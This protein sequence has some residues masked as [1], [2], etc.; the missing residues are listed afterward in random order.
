MAPPTHLSSKELEMKKALMVAL[1]AMSPTT[2]LMAEDIDLGIQRRILGAT[3]K[4]QMSNT[5]D[6]SRI[7]SGGSGT[8]I[9]NSRHIGEDGVLRRI[10]IATAEHVI[11]QSFL[12]EGGD[13]PGQEPVLTDISVHN[14]TAYIRD[15]TGQV[16]GEDKFTPY[17]SRLVSSYR[18]Y[19]YKSVDAAFIVMD[20][21]PGCLWMSGVE[22]VAM[23]GTPLA[24]SLQI[25]SELL[26]AGCPIMVDPILFRN[27]LVQRNM[28]KLGF[29]TRDFLGHLVSRVLTHGN[30]GGGIYTSDGKYIGIV[31]LRI[32]DDFGAFTGIE[33]IL[34]LSILDRDVMLLM[35]P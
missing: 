15:S 10:V 22:A 16:R 19:R 32:G 4:I 34:P 31:T 2:C 30:S 7:S 5:F 20:L 25:G 14:F 33:H 6:V 27:R 35:N 18:V 12:A 1:L 24:S 17:T 21:L 3:V 29:R 11:P 8:V 9:F 28:K 13:D 26:V 23:A